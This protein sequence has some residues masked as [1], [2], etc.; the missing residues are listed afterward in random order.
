VRRYRDML[1]ATP[2]EGY[3]RCCEAIRDLDLRPD[4]SRIEAPTTLIFGR[5]DPVVPDDGR[6]AL[7][8]IPGAQ[9]VELDAAH[10]ANVEQPHAFSAAL[11]P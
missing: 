11:L 1:A 10:L 2:A 5:H 7:A 8:S 4:L 3:A 6:R 9:V